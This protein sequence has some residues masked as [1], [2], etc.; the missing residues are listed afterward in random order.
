MPVVLALV[1]GMSGAA[2]LLLLRA[3]LAAAKAIVLNLCSVAA[4]YGLVVYVFQQG[5]GAAFFGLPGPAEVIPT[6]V[7]IVIFS[8]L[9]GLS[10]DYEIFLISRI[11]SLFL[12]NGDND[13]SIVDALA[14][15][16]SIIT[17]AALIMAVVFGAFAFSR[18]VIVQMIGLGLA[19]AILVDAFLIRSIL[20]PAMMK[21]A[22]R[23]NWWPLTASIKEGA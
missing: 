16:G 10:R 19:A 7:P 12:E 20:G 5:H 6:T 23:W 17:N 11:R 15:T 21:I 2:L 1:I 18:I 4:G 3:P 8:I 22:G 14:D 9:F 13:R